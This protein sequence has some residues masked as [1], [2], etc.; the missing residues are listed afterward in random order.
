MKLYSWLQDFQ[1]IENIWIDIRELKPGM[2]LE[3]F[4]DG[5]NKSDIVIVIVS[6]Y[7]KDSEYVKEEIEYS[8]EFQERKEK[9]VIPA[10]YKIKPDHIP[11]HNR[12]HHKLLK[13]IY[14]ALDDNLF[15]IHKIIPSLIPDHYVI[16]IPFDRD[17]H[18]DIS[19]LVDKLRAYSERGGELYPLIDHERFDK[20]IITV[21][22]E[23]ANEDNS[24]KSRQ[25][26][27]I[28][29][30]NMLLLFWTNTSFIL[31]EHIQRFIPNRRIYTSVAESIHNLFQELFHGLFQHIFDTF[32]ST[33]VVRSNKSRG[34]KKMMEK[35]AK[36]IF[37]IGNHDGYSYFL[38][39]LY[40]DNNIT[41]HNLVRFNFL[42]S[43]IRKQSASISKYGYESTISY[44]PTAPVNEIRDPDWH[45]IIIPQFLSYE[46]KRA[47]IDL[48]S[49]N[50]NDL[51]EIG[52]DIQDYY[53]LY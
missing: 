13:N 36:Y 6:K 47:T 52:L 28:F 40:Y 27:D 46:I 3:S 19:R 22:E 48:H 51:E 44:L 33:A 32:M 24:T 49:L 30:L 17:F 23:L 15:S 11:L 31:S 5:I 45:E 41:P 38:C 29:R 20:Q 25:K 50:R 8:L 16:E 26:L 10:L 2:K 34:M 42:G 14:V 37:P 53:K 4:F 21:F 39:D 18:I 35:S 9:I 12:Q 7:S 43:R 1:F